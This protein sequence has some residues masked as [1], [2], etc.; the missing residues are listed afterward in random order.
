MYYSCSTTT[1]STKSRVCVL[2]LVHT[3]STH[4]WVLNLILSHTKKLVKKINI[5]V[6]TSITYYLIRF[7]FTSFVMYLWAQVIFLLFCGKW[8]YQCLTLHGETWPKFKQVTKV[9]PLR[10]LFTTPRTLQHFWFFCFVWGD[11]ASVALSPQTRQKI[12]VGYSSKAK[13]C[14]VRDFLP[15]IGT[16]YVLHIAIGIAW[17]EPAVW[18]Y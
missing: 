5:L 6:W 4:T 11:T 8:P 2:N 17:N 13:S 15:L 16:V 1:Y 18:V 3:F 9:K 12:K 7:T 14:N 10:Y